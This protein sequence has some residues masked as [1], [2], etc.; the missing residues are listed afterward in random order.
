ML[1]TWENANRKL[2]GGGIILFTAEHKN[3]QRWGGGDTEMR[4]ETHQMIT[5]FGKSKRVKSTCTNFI[6][7]EK[8]I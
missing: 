5:N 3:L 1:S 2:E 6:N 8:L 7:N 4:G